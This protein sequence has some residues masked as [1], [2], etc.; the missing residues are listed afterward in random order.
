VRELTAW[1][2]R[3]DRVVAA[4]SRRV[5]RSRV[6]FNLK[7]AKRLRKGGYEVVLMAT[8]ADGEQ[9]YMAKRVKLR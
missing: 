4:T 3:G 7:S 9:S 2:Q 8:A 1:L 6:E 5:K